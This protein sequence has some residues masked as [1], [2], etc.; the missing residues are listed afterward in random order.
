MMMMGCKQLCY[1]E[2]L[3]VNEV[4]FLAERGKFSCIL[5]SSSQTERN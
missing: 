2:Q 4:L 3:D 5:V 1:G